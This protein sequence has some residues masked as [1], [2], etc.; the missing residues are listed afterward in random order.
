MAYRRNKSAQGGNMKIGVAG[1][2]VMGSALAARLID[3]GHDVSV[4][5]RSAEKAKPL[6]E[7]GAK[8]AGSPAKL[9]EANDAVITILTDG[10]AID[11]VYNGPNGLLSGDVKGKLLIEMS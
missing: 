2:G 4:W 5:N 6:V 8:V 3:L 1:L 10:A 9:A 7:A 11:A